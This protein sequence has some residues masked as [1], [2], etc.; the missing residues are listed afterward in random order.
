MSRNMNK[1]DALQ[2][3]AETVDKIAQSGI[4]PT[5]SWIVQYKANDKDHGDPSTFYT[6]VPE[7]YAAVLAATK[8]AEMMEYTGSA[9][10]ITTSGEF[11]GDPLRNGLDPCFGYTT[12]VFTRDTS[13]PG[14]QI[15][16]GPGENTSPAPSPAPS[17]TP[18]NLLA[19]SA[20]CC[21]KTLFLQTSLATEEVWAGER[22]CRC[23]PQAGPSSTSR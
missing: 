11:V 2:M 6:E 4:G 18:S 22:V 7:G 12:I 17:P 14:M 16:N 9:M 8:L 21:K 1:N 3:D 10:T 20:A 13:P 5:A 23:P 19:W 15:S